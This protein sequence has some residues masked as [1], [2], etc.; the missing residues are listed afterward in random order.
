MIRQGD[1]HLAD[2]GNAGRRPVVIVSRDALNRGG[3]VVAVAFTSARVAERRALPNCVF[4]RV[5][6]F[7]LTVDCVAQCE[8]IANVSVD[9]LDVPAIGTLDAIAL[10]SVINAIGNVIDADCEPG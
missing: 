8:T 1:V 2:L 9:R 10:R 4:F 5:G 3:Y 7:G 6:E